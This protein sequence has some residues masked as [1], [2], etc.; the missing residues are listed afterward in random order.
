M[1]WYMYAPLTETL[2]FHLLAQVKD[3]DIGATVVSVYTFLA[4][5]G[6]TNRIRRMPKYVILLCTYTNLDIKPWSLKCF[7]QSICALLHNRYGIRLRTGNYINN[8]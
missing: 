2:Y 6:Q 7:F 4:T 1:Y 3:M 5:R 8:I